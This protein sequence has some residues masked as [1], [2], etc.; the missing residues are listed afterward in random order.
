M[1]TTPPN[2][3]SLR[4]AIRLLLG[5]SLASSA[6]V[7]AQFVQAVTQANGDTDRPEAQFTGNTVDIRNGGTLIR[8][9][10]TVPHFGPRALCMTDRAHEWNAVAT[11]VAIPRT[12]VARPTS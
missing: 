9:G 5:L 6:A 3:P 11:N 7:Q 1:K 2:N 12:S 4:R 10:Y 8:A